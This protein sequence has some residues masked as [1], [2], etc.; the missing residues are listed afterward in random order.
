[1]LITH[2][3]SSTPTMEMRRVS[4]HGERHGQPAECRTCFAKPSFCVIILYKG[5]CTDFGKQKQLFNDSH[6]K[7]K[8]NEQDTEHK[9]NKKGYMYEGACLCDLNV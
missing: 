3:C 5:T 2:K 8:N 4:L 1:M 9:A 7:K 6:S